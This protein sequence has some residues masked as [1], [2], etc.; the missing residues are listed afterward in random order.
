MV[1]WKTSPGN[2]KK[3]L[4]RTQSGFLGQERAKGKMTEGEGR[5][6]GRLGLCTWLQCRKY[7]EV[8][9]L[10]CQFLGFSQDQQASSPDCAQHSLL[11]LLLQA[12]SAF[13]LV[14]GK[15]LPPHLPSQLNLDT[16]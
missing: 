4:A 9:G 15:G 12:S 6:E 13:I 11:P 1:T 16:S 3:V 7:L 5:A 8:L 14:P 10:R 2:W